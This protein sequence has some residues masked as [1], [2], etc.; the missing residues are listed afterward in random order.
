MDVTNDCVEQNKGV[1]VALQ[2]N[3]LDGTTSYRLQLEENGGLTIYKSLG[4]WATVNSFK[5]ICTTK[6]GDLPKT[7]II[8]SDKTN[9]KAG[10]TG[11]HYMVKNGICY[12]ALDIVTTSASTT[13]VTLPNIGLPKASF[14]FIHRNIAPYNTTGGTALTVAIANGRI[15]LYNSINGNRYLDSFSY[16]VAES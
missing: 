16:T 8:W 7:N 13:V 2:N 6:V 9:Y 12:V 5:A 3:L 10:E 4:K 15:T 1:W 14:D 11:C